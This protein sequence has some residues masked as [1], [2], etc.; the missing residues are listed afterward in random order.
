LPVTPTLDAVALR[1]ALDRDVEIA[2]SKMQAPNS[3]RISE[4]LG[5]FAARN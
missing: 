1:V 4:C 2:L 3:S 5:A